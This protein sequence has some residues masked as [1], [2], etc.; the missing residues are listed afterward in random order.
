MTEGKDV[1]MSVK[2]EVQGSVNRSEYSC[3]Y[4]GS[5]FLHWAGFAEKPEGMHKLCP[6]NRDDSLLSQYSAFFPHGQK[7]IK[8]ARLHAMLRTLSL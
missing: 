4:S 3:M 8:H 7:Q 2:V 6:E 1:G 5:F